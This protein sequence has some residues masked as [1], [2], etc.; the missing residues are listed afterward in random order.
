MKC[1]PTQFAPALGLPRIVLA[2]AA[3]LL[4]GL[5]NADRFAIE[6]I[7]AN[8]KSGFNF[9]YLLRVPEHLRSSDIALVV[10]TNNTG[11]IDE[12]AETLAATRSAAAG[13]SLGPLLSEWLQVPLLMPVF[14]RTKKD[15]LVYTHALDRDS[16][17]IQEGPL[18]RLDRQLLA[19]VDDASHNGTTGSR[20][21]ALRITLWIGKNRGAEPHTNGSRP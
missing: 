2:I 19:M 18:A 8:P 13:S 15:S 7:D 20:F 14:P 16:I 5:A 9:P 4:T 1:R 11:N 21:A 3:L 17:L 10:E 6:V 12:F